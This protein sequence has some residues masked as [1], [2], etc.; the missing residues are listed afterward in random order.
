MLDEDGAGEVVEVVNVV[1]GEFF[2]KSFHEGEVL[3]EGD[4][5][6][7]RFERVEEGAEHDV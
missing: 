7:G 2:F 3:M 4:G 6:T 1:G 5:E